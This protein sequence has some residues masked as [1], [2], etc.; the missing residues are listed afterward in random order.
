M[1]QFKS[2]IF[3]AIFGL[4]IIVSGCLGNDTTIKSLS[5]NRQTVPEPTTTLTPIPTQ[6]TPTHTPTLEEMNIQISKEVVEEYHQTHTYYGKD[7]FVCGDM[8][9]DVWNMLKTRGIN[10]KIQIGNVDKDNA[11]LFE[12]NHAWVLA[13]VSADK[14]LALETTGGYLV[15]STDNPRYYRGWN[16]YTPKQFKEYLQLLTQYNDQLSKYN[17]AVTQYNNLISQYNQA[18]IIKKAT[19][20]GQVK[21]QATIVEQR[22]NDLNEVISKMKALLTY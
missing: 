18:N 21:T 9:N 3:I 7:I 15:Y 8:A 22:T 11:T 10:A 2:I 5:G 16:F 17:D 12:S 6:I 14:W 4:A 19:L 20:S 1:V 13:E